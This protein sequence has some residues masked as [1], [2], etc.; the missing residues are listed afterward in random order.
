VT[1]TRVQLQLHKYLNRYF[2]IYYNL[3]STQLSLVQLGLGKMLL[4]LSKGS[5]LVGIVSRSSTYLRGG[6]A[7]AI[8]LAVELLV[9]F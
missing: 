2:R 9:V 8:L 6:Q 3:V 4:C 1:E 5:R 7:C